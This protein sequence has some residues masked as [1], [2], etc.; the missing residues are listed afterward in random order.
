M[1]DFEERLASSL[2]RNLPDFSAFVSLKRLSGGASQETY[3]VEIEAKDGP[4]TLAVRRAA[5]SVGGTG[6]GPGVAGEAELFRIA[7]AAG[8]PEP[9]IFHVFS[10]DE[11]LGE[12]FVM[13]WLEGETVGGRILRARELD[14]VRPRLAFQCGEVLARIHGIDPV[15]AKL[16]E[17]LATVST[18][19]YVT[20]VWERYQSFDTAMPMIDYTARWLLDHLPEEA[21][22]RLVHNDFRNGNV[23]VSPEGIVAVLDWELAHLGDPIRDLGWIC[24]NSWR[25]GRSELRVGGFG[26]LE[27]LLD[28]Y[29]SVS[30]IRV[31]PEH[32]H[33]WEVFGSYW[34]AATSLAMAT[35]WRAGADKTVER[36]AIA[37]RSS[38]C[39]VDCANLII[40]GPVQLVEAETPAS[41][42][43]MPRVDELLT[44]VRDF[45]REDAR[46][47]LEGR[48]AFLALVASNSLDIV[49]RE[50]SLGPAHLRGEGERL[51]AIFESDE[52]L[53]AL[54]RRLCAGLRDGSIRLDRAGLAEHLRT[55]A[56]NQ[57]AIDQPKYSGL[58][59]A[60]TEGCQ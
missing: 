52:A 5:I 46:G 50:L 36:P 2:A 38:E 47:T 39:Q 25:F 44:S 17:H 33:F 32:V 11:G 42:V 60:I 14:E 12:G 54:R 20:E 56:A 48:N 24:T 41:S 23:M 19:D 15:A 49:Q 35:F 55:T 8:V 34:W 16:D 37:R 28:G 3:R 59:M 58:A 21:P 7:R 6:Q 1:T 10:E 51:R 27:D 13:E 9:E 43:D 31:E 4:R 40:P 26:H 30:G 29:E 53:E 45:L 18:R 57:L 22:P